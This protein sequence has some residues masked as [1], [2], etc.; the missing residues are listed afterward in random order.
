MQSS[1]EVAVPVMS[2]EAAAEV[3]SLVEHKHLP[4]ALLIL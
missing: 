2:A 3:A 4:M 1:L